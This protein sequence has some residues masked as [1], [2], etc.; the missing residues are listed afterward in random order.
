[1]V[2][3]Q[4]KLISWTLVQGL[5]FL[6]GVFFASSGNAAPYDFTTTTTVDNTFF[7]LNDLATTGLILRAGRTLTW[8][9]SAGKGIDGPIIIESGALLKILTGK[10]LLI[11]TSLFS[12]GTVLVY[13]TLNNGIGGT[14]DNLDTIANNGTVTNNGT[15]NNSVGSSFSNKGTL[16]NNG[17]MNNSDYFENFETIVNAG[18]LNNSGTLQSTNTVNNSGVLNN[19]SSGTIENDGDVNN[20]GTLNNS[21]TWHNGDFSTV[22]NSGIIGLAIGNIVK[23]IIIAA[24]HFPVA[25]GSQFDF[26]G[27]GSVVPLLMSGDIIRELDGTVTPAQCANGFV[28]AP[29]ASVT[30]RDRV[31]IGTS[32]Y[33]VV[34]AGAN[35]T[36][37]ASK[38]FANKGVVSI[39]AGGSLNN[40]GITNN[41]KDGTIDNSGTI[42]IAKTGAINNR[43]IINNESSGIINN[44]GEM[45]M[46]KGGI[47]NDLGSIVSKNRR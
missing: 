43:G 39:V 33:V 5:F 12:S 21:G 13:G 40:K 19:T 34:S 1:M 28:V 14:F 25:R 22:L 31:D 41:N 8:N 46:K 45:N 11:N 35:L 44:S 2:V 9:Y 7:A 42:N 26:T 16:N 18:T 32:G 37:P 30:V 29:E 6:A 36:I 4:N 38:V 15:W 20:S 3:M 27:D 10:E 23:N 24:T 17:T 47:L